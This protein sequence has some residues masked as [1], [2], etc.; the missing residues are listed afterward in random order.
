MANEIGNGITSV[1]GSELY[2]N[3]VA[4][5]MYTANERSVARELVRMFDISAGPGKTIQVPVYPT[6]AAAAVAEGDDLTSTALN[7]TSVDI[8]VA[9]FGVMTEV[10]DLMAS[11]STTNMAADVG[12]IMGEAMGKKMDEDVFALFSSFTTSV[13][14]NNDAEELDADLIFKAAATLRSNNAPGNYFCVA[15]PKAVYNLKKTLVNNGA[16]I[17]SLSDVGNEALRTGIIGTVAGVTII[18]STAVPTSSGDGAIN[19][20]FSDQ[21]IGMAMKRDMNLETER[22]ASL[23]ATEYVMTSAKGQAILKNTYGVQIITDASL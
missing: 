16:N 14:D 18:E 6:I 4:E 21:A 7:P 2:A 15:H 22:N 3:I 9:E 1:V 10:T 11:S 8:T 5:A 12:F 23:R 20:V 17:G 13:G 19:A